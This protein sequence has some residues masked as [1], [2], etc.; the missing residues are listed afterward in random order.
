MEQQ[1]L[2]RTVRVAVAPGSL[3]AETSDTGEGVH[4]RARRPPRS[5]CRRT[6]ARQAGSASDEEQT[7]RRGVVCD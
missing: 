3:D 1:I 2:A 4:E 5:R 6:S 7:R